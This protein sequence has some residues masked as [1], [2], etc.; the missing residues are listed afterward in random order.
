[1]HQKLTYKPHSDWMIPAVIE[2]GFATAG[3]REGFFSNRRI[4][5]EHRLVYKFVETGG[6]VEVLTAVCRYHYG[7]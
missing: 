1:M 4:T 7:N 6:G 2:D 3:L 5:D